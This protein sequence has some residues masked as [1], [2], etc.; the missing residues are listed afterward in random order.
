MRKALDSKEL[1][2]IAK[3]SPTKKALDLRVLPPNHRFH[4]QPPRPEAIYLE[5]VIV[6]LCD[7]ID[8]LKAEISRLKVDVTKTR[9]GL[10]SPW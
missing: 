5:K 4:I 10:H 1:E 3:G 6:L 8:G 9:R 7:Q 2:E